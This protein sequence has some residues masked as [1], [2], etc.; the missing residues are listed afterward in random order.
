[1]HIH[2]FLP[3]IKNNFTFLF[4]YCSYRQTKIFIPKPTM[5]NLLDFMYMTFKNFTETKNQ[6]KVDCVKTL[7]FVDMLQYANSTFKV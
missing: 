4:A 6:R 7:F 1:M 3:R 2:T 5:V